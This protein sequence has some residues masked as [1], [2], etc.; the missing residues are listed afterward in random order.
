MLKT[1]DAIHPTD[2]DRLITTLKSIKKY[3][4]N[5]GN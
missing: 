2:L 5:K 1:Y 4:Y 3:S